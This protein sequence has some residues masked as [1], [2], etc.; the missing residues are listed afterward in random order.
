MCRKEEI[1]KNVFLVS[2]LLQF[3]ILYWIVFKNIID[4]KSVKPKVKELVLELSF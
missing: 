4:G 1:Y 3:N 2:T